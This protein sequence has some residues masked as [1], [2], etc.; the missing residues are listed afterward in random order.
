MRKSEKKPW[1]RQV[2]D[3]DVPDYSRDHAGIYR[4]R[5]AE[6]NGETVAPP[7]AVLAPSQFSTL[8]E[9]D[10]NNTVDQH[11]HVDVIREAQ[12][13]S[14]ATLV[15][16]LTEDEL[17]AEIEAASRETKLGHNPSAN[18]VAP[19]P[20][21]SDGVTAASFIGVVEGTG[22]VFSNPNRQESRAVHTL[23]K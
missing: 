7:P 13:R 11:P 10:P 1:Y 6:E 16:Q 17:D 4:E 8:P 23:N 22:V 2:E 15:E 12:R 5:P 14:A 20:V 3:G 9:G 21:H 18:A 19:H